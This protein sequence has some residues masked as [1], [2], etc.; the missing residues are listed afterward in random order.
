MERRSSYVLYGISKRREIKRGYAPRT[1]RRYWSS[2]PSTVSR[3]NLALSSR[4]RKRGSSRTTRTNPSQSERRTV[5]FSPGPGSGV[6]L[7][8]Q[9]RA[10]KRW[11]LHSRRSWFSQIS[12]SPQSE[13]SNPASSRSSRFAAESGPSPS[14]T[15]QAMTDKNGARPGCSSSVYKISPDSETAMTATESVPFSISNVATEPSKSFSGHW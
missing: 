12:R 4:I 9:P 13:D 15:P 5:T 7:A 8:L 6:I 1:F 11:K 2:S 14:S 10:T 3:R